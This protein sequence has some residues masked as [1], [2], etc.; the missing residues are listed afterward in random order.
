MRT[1]GPL[2]TLILAV[3]L[4][5][6]AGLYAENCSTCPFMAKRG[7][8]DS[9]KAKANAPECRELPGYGKK[10]W[11]GQDFYF[12]Y[13]FDKKPKM[14]T[15][16]LKVM[17]YDKADKQVKDWEIIGWSG[18]PSMGGAHDTEAT[19]KQ[20]KNGEYRLPVNVVMPGEWEIRLTLS[21]D[22]KPVY[23]GCFKFKV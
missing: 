19:L 15:A 1:R 21:K 8:P 3:T 5:S 18:M 16:I 7:M 22:K 20:A 4:L 11:I 13:K 23:V 17:L 12:T 10:C 14:G 2:V 9:C 6:A